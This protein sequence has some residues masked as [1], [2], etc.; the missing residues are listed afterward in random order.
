MAFVQGSILQ[1]ETQ[2]SR[3]GKNKVASWKEK[4]QCQTLCKNPAS[5][6]SKRMQFTFLVTPVYA[7]QTDMWADFTI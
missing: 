7:T 6:L 3:A 5:Y 1:V 4:P 2:L